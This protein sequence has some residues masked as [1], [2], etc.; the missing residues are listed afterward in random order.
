MYFSKYEDLDYFW[1]PTE[2]FTEKFD[3]YLH[4]SIFSSLFFAI[5]HTTK[6]ILNGR[7]KI[8]K[9]IIYN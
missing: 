1:F 9:D 5:D 8:F 3:K 6:E 7:D 2:E 4:S